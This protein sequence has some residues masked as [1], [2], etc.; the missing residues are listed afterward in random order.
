MDFLKV[1]RNIFLIV[2]MVFMS[3]ICYGAEVQ[4]ISF[5]DEVKEAPFTMLGVKLNDD[6]QIA[7]EPFG[8]STDWIEI[9]SV[10][11][12]YYHSPENQKYSRQINFNGK[13]VKEEIGFYS[14]NGK[15]AGITVSFFSADIATVRIIYNR[16][17]RYCSKTYDGFLD[18]F[19]RE[20]IPDSYT[21]EPYL[22]MND[23]KI[24]QL[25]LKDMRED[26]RTI[27]RIVG[28]GNTPLSKEDL[29]ESYKVS[30]YVF[31]KSLE[32]YFLP[33][34]WARE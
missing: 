6:F 19:K 33:P 32:N 4:G 17:Y 26:F 20:V 24:I 10:G 11:P 21:R 16:L 2:F 13:A 27:Y 5:I 23:G 28:K 9:T 29:A 12:V 18:R 34:K 8:Q 14:I 3:N 22:I 1:M 30:Y 31:D 25:Y 7:T 15:I